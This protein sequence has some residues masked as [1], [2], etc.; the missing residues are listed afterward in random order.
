M[1]ININSVLKKM[2]RKRLAMIMLKRHFAQM[3][4]IVDKAVAVDLP[5]EF[6]NFTYEELAHM[7]VGGVLFEL[8]WRF[9]TV[10]IE[11][12]RRFNYDVITAQLGEDK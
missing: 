3:E 2:E 9:K 10:K 6:N 5:D 11:R 8:D 12:L 7:I 4:D 1:A